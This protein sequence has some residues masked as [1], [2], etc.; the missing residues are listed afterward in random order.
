MLRQIRASRLKTLALV[1]VACATALPI[2]A[3]I[4]W[5]RWSLGLMARN[6]GLHQDP[7]TLG[8]AAALLPICL[9][10]IELWLPIR[11][12]RADTPLTTSERAPLSEA[13]LHWNA[14]RIVA[15]VCIVLIELVV[16]VVPE[17]RPVAA[18]QHHA[19]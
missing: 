11:I 5:S 15:V 12:G 13:Q 10:A 1:A 7:V 8:M 9:V 19:R 2:A 18:A 14:V 4:M 17:H 6:L 16:Q 3:S